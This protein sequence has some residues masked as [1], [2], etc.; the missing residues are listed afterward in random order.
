MAADVPH[1][2]DHAGRHRA[3]VI[4]CST[5]AAHGVY[6]D[7][8]GPVI[9]RRLHTWGLQVGEP[10]VVPDGPEVA[11][12]LRVAVDAG[13]HL[14]VTTGGTGLSPTDVTPELTNELIDRPVPGIAEAI[15]GHGLKSGIPTAMLSR[16]VA[17]LAGSTL[18]VNLPGSRGGVLDGLAVLEPVLHHALDQA[19]GGGDH[20]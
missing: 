14:V 7:R 12:A 8:T 13:T 5:R 3:A 2:G 18:I 6:E 9:V 15:R 19:A 11:A 1:R 4:C 16:G 17:G 10:V 20:R